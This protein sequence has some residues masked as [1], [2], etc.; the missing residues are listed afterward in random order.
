ME[1]YLY[2]YLVLEYMMPFK[3]GLDILQFKKVVLNIV[4]IIILKE[5]KLI[6]IIFLPVENRMNCKIYQCYI[7]KELTFLK[8]LLVIRRVN[9]KIGIF[10]TI[11]IFW[12]KCLSFNRFSAIGV[13]MC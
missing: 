13:M 6:H 10:G 4:L 8:V 5:T 9:Q 3:I 11:G 12:I 7:M 1:L 2:Y